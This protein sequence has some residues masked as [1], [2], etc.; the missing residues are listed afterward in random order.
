MIHK[1]IIILGGSGFVGTNLSKYFLKYYNKYQVTI[2]GNKTKFKNIFTKKENKKIKIYN[3]DIYDA[4]KLS[5]KIFKDAIII[6]T[7]LM[8]NISLKDFSKRYFE[9]C[10]F[11]NQNNISKFVLLS[12]ISVYGKITE[13]ITSEKTKI[14]PISVYGKRCV[15]AEKITKKFFKNKLIILRMANIFGKYRSK[16]GTIEKLI[17]NLLTKSKYDLINSNKKRT[18]IYVDTLVRIISMLIDKNLK[19][20]IIF[21]IA[22]PNYIFNFEELSNRVSKI[23]NKKITYFSYKNKIKK[24]YESICLPKTFMK[25][26]SYKFKN[27]FKNEVFEVAKFIKSNEK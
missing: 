22:N 24:N 4:K 5:K 3:I 9:L 7:S 27:N 21:N 19:K 2:I 10:N 1:K 11:F 14:N 15:S 26:F 18:Y 6:N 12:S 8:T 16:K 23:F 13:A 20:Y 25:K 17:S